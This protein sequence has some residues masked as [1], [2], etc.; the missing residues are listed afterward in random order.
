MSLAQRIAD[1]L[2]K[3]QPGLLGS[4]RPPVEQS[5]DGGEK[6][7]RED[8]QEHEEHAA[9]PLPTPPSPSSLPCPAEPAPVG[10]ISTEAPSA[11]SSTS[12]TAAP[13]ES[14]PHYQPPDQSTAIYFV[15][16]ADADK[17]KPKQVFFYDYGEGSSGIDGR[18]VW[19]KDTFT[20]QKQDVVV[21]HLEWRKSQFFRTYGNPASVKTDPRTCVEGS[22]RIEWELR[23]GGTRKKAFVSGVRTK[24]QLGRGVDVLAPHRPM[25]EE[26][27]E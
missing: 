1:K 7:P 10:P 26:S 12:G 24:M 2:K 19:K 5:E 13:P 4:K 14:N 6:K 15:D 16:K 17:P 21:G 23:R 27:A 9:H 3:T 18:W 20:H 8:N 25:G 11:P 22:K